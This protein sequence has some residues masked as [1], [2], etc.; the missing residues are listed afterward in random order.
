[1]LFESILA[2]IL[3][4]IGATA[5]LQ[6]GGFIGALIFSTGLVCIISMKFKLFTGQ[7]GNVLFGRKDGAKPKVQDLI[8]IWL[9]NLIGA[10]GAGLLLRIS[11]I[12]EELF[13]KARTIVMKAFTM[14]F[15]GNIILGL[16]CG[17][18]MYCAT[19]YVDLNWLR[20]VLC[21]VAFI[22]CGFAHSIAMMGY[23]AVGSMS[24]V[25]WWILIPI[26]LGNL[27]GSWIIPIFQRVGQARSYRNN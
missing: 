24:V 19:Y 16:F 25:E 22:M 14:G 10:G 1:M 5:Y 17:L 9:G 18:L 21:V 2:G 6:I 23:L 15:G 11:P 8:I 4:M 26:T 20:T 13:E 12:G 27:F 3:I 7:C